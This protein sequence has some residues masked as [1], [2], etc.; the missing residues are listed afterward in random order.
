MPHNRNRNRN[1]NNELHH[2]YPEKG[3]QWQHS[4]LPSLTSFWCYFPRI[5]NLGTNG[6]TETDNIRNSTSLRKISWNEFLIATGR[7]T[8]VRTHESST[9]WCSKRNKTTTGRGTTN[10]VRDVNP[11]RNQR[12]RNQQ[13]NINRANENL[14]DQVF[15]IFRKGSVIGDNLQ[16][17]EQRSIIQTLVFHFLFKIEYYLFF[18]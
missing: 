17:G 7:T 3:G 16:L 8:F 13:R 9:R 18:P 2:N 4:L 11:Q 15:Q 14:R 10:S 5:P 1:R 12:N 6:G